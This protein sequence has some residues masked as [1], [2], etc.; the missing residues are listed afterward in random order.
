MA[1]AALGARGLEVVQA[2]RRLQRAFEELESRIEART[3]SLARVNEQYRQAQHEAEAANRAKSEF[4][5]NMSH[6][7]RTPMNGVLGMI[8]LLLDTNLDERQADYVRTIQ[9]STRALFATISDVLDF[10]RIEAGN[11]AIEQAP[12]AP[13]ALIEEVASLLRPAAA[14]KG[15]ELV[16]RVAGDVPEQVLGDP[17]RVRQVLT[18]LAGNAVKFTHEG[19]VTIEVRRGAGDGD[20]TVLEWRV[21]DTGIGI[22]PDQLKRIFQAFTQVDATAARRFGG[23]GLGLAISQRLAQLMGGAIEVSS[24]FG[25]GSTF[26]LRLPAPAAPSAPST[27]P[28]ACDRAP[29]RRV[30]LA[31]DDPVNQRVAVHLLE[32]LGCC[33]TVAGN[34]RVAV[35]LLKQERF[36]LVF[37]DCQMP[38]LNG[39]EAAQLIRD[40]AS[41]V[42]E[43]GVP[44]IALTASATSDEKKRCLQAGMSD[45]LTKPIL[46]GALRAALERWGASRLIGSEPEGRGGERSD[47][48]RFPWPPG[49]ERDSRCIVC[50]T[51]AQR[52]CEA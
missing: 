19:A 14:G 23:V 35:E 46:P 33:V 41:G 52:L 12:Y 11:M 17:A 37:M 28:A 51:N 44:V 31:E 42:L 29:P 39:Y 3:R 1:E 43:P 32:K 24:T 26:R 25:R 5:A 36:D 21:K 48:G 9:D 34:G 27:E 30:L 8:Q 50:A 16:T 22:A 40:P 18:N 20:Q 10:S 38:E 49:A 6:E 4:L 2:H 45:F 7:I 13:R 15:L 47:R